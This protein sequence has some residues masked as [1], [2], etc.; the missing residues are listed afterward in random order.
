M[1]RIF[2]DTETTGLTP[3]QIGQLA[4]IKEQDTG[5]I[6]TYNYF[7]DVNYVEDGAAKV[8][9]RNKEWY[10]QA[11][12]GKKFEEYADEILNILNSGTLVAHNMQFDEKFMSAEFWRANKQF[13]P[14]S[15]FDTMVY[16][17]DI[18]KIP[19]KKYGRSSSNGSEYKYPKLEEL[20]DFLKINRE[21]VSKYALSL[22]NENSGDFHDARYDTAVMFVA[23]HVY[24]DMLEN[25]NGWIKAFCNN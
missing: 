7:F 3:G 15:K 16:F 4:I 18:C 10:H 6:T 11:S 5:E 9:G 14:V 21:K 13:T 1:S 8:T 23:F 12:N 2:L 19:K 20:A 17:T 22:F 25:T 24:K